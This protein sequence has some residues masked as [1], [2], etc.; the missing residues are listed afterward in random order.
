LTYGEQFGF[1]VGVIGL[2]PISFYLLTPVEFIQISEQYSRAE[3]MKMDMF[4]VAV[5][6]GAGL[7][8]NGK[9]YKPLFDEKKTNSQGYQK[10]DPETRDADLKYLREKFNL[11]GGE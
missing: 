1:A 11:Q 5:Y 3:Q 7:M 6:H 8:L 9:P 10:V 2:S 4:G